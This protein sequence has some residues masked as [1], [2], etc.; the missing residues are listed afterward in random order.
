MR[1]VARIR[2]DEESDPGPSRQLGAFFER[3]I[4]V[5]VALLLLLAGSI[6]GS[7]MLNRLLV[8]ATSPTV[9]GLCAYN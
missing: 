8:L 4:D 6:P 9:S 1:L 3:G 5:L 7:Q 2:D